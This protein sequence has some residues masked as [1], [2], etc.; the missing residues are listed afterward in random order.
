MRINKKKIKFVWDKSAWDKVDRKKILTGGLIGIGILILAVVLILQIVKLVKEKNIEE[1]L[2]SSSYDCVQIELTQEMQEIIS[3]GEAELQDETGSSQASEPYS[4]RSIIKK[5]GDI[6]YEETPVGNAYYYI[7]DDI[8]YALVQEATYGPENA[9]GLWVETPA[10]QYALT[11]FEFR[12]L[13]KLS[14]EDLIEKNGNFL[15][16]EDK[17]EDFYFQFFKVSNTDYHKELTVEFTFSH[18]KI[19]SIVARYLYHD[20]IYETDTCIFSYE[21]EK[22]VIP[23]VDDTRDENGL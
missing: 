8:E 1:A 14:R 9:E 10:E 5:D 11:Q 22:L 4:S 19:A 13:D 6:I 3:S 17:A 20:Q 23:E 15:L 2:M 18:G 7:R 12:A 16:S 21:K